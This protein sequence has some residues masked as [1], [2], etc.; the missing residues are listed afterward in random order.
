MKYKRVE[1]KGELL[2]DDLVELILD[3]DFLVLNIVADESSVRDNAALDE[4]LQTNELTELALEIE[5]VA[6]IGNQIDIALAL[7]NDS[8]EFI[9]V[10]IAKRPYCTH[11]KII[12][13]EKEL[14]E[15]KHTTNCLRE[16][17]RRN[18]IEAP[19]QSPRSLYHILRQCQ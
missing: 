14:L 18:V 12:L 15:K 13:S 2:F 6:I 16:C 11:N 1:D 8:E 19:S 3:K 17:G 10:N 4:L 5:L 7:V 9:N